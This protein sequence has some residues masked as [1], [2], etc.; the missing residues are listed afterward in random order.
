MLYELQ[1]FVQGLAPFTLILGMATLFL[2]L[3]HPSMRAARKSNMVAYVIGLIF[4][5]LVV[6]QSLVFTWDT[7]I[8]LG[9]SEI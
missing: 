5:I 3:T 8:T 2:Y 1:N 9:L 6:L 7:F 4:L